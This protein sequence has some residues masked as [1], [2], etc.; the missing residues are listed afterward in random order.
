MS[1]KILSTCCLEPVSQMLPEYT[2]TRRPESSDSGD[3]RR[4]KID[5]RKGENG[6]ERR[7]KEAKNLRRRDK[8][9]SERARCAMDGTTFS[10]RNHGN[11]HE[12]VNFRRSPARFFFCLRPRFNRAPFFFAS[13][14]ISSASRPGRSG[15]G[16]STISTHL[17]RSQFEVPVRFVPC[18]RWRVCLP[19]GC[20]S[21]ESIPPGL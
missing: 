14:Y 19:L 2:T 4:S 5:R 9:E 15:P 7:R 18:S 10:L 21:G 6:V 1:G 16:G 11:H 20:L 13:S 17:L 12:S 8:D 3:D